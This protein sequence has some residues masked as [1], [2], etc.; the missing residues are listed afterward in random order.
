MGSGCGWYI[1]SRIT[2]GG[3]Q[4]R[5][6]AGGGGGGGGGGNLTVTGDDAQETYE[7]SRVALSAFV[8][9]AKVLCDILGHPWDCLSKVIRH[10]DVHYYID[11]GIQCLKEL[12]GS[13]RR[14]DGLVL[15]T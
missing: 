5:K 4:D 12:G 3:I 11:M 15:S 10:E 6:A 9:H 14:S 2:N 8:I 7:A 1:R 13:V